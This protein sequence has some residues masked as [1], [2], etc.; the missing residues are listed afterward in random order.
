MTVTPPSAEN[1]QRVYEQAAQA[2]NTGQ[3]Q[4][5]LEY[6]EIILATHP[7]HPEVLHLRGRIALAL[8][9]IAAAHHWIAL[10]LQ[11]QPNPNFYNS[12]SV[13]QTRLR[14]FSSAAESAQQGLILARR[15]TPPPDI[16]L[17]LYNLGRALQLDGEFE[18]ALDHYRNLIAINPKH[19]EAHN[20]A[21]I[22]LKDLGELESAMWHLNQAMALRPDNHEARFNFANTL[23][24]AGRY[25]DAWPY[26]EFRGQSLKN[27]DGKLIV[28]PPPPLPQWQGQDVSVGKH[29]LL[30]FH[31]QGLGDT[32]QFARYLSMA[33]ARFAVVGFVCPRSLHRLLKQSFCTRWP[34]LLLFDKPP[35]NLDDWDWYSLLMSLPMAF[36]TRIDNI[37]AALY[38]HADAQLAETWRARLARLGPP[39][40]ARIGLVWA[41]GEYSGS[42]TD[43][44]RSLA[45]E[46]IAPLLAWPHACWVSLQQA[47]NPAKQLSPEQRSK[48][49]DWMSEISDFADTAALIEHLDLVIAV[50]TSVAHL[51]AAMG[52]RVWLLNRHA[53]CWRWLRDRD[54]S[55]WY[56][57]LRLFTQTRG[58]AWDE[59]LARVVGA[60]EQE[61]RSKNHPNPGTDHD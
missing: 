14:E 32:L 19:S 49:A 21:G 31:E 44:K 4:T 36:G 12:L 29:S 17:L 8:D 1:L 24:A 5:A 51:A 41:G 47:A 30:V 15:M 2:Y 33:L 38:L 61:R 11:V 56:P 48:I 16:S 34:N 46:Q 54:D 13:V 39:E 35:A 37:P 27:G 57:S 28:P 6:V 26:Y 59:V 22:I 58:G 42:V 43:R 10:A 9:E 52:K 60:L 7:E 55:P 3:W 50:D 18:K 40:L 45:P 25:E 53:G 20:N 23:L